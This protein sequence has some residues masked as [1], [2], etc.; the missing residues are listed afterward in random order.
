[1]PLKVVPRKKG[2][3]IMRL[4]DAIEKYCT[5]DHPEI[6]TIL[7]EESVQREPVKYNE[8]IEDLQNGLRTAKEMKTSLSINTEAHKETEAD[9]KRRARRKPGIQH[10]LPQGR[11]NDHSDRWQ[12]T[13][14]TACW[15]I[16]TLPTSSLWEKM[17]Q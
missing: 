6:R 11:K 3:A 17:I 12:G 4:K 1:M 16:I 8:L 9:E 10:P 7:E 13:D 5:D 14:H 2:T 15:K